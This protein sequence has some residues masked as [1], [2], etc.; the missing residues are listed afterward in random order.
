MFLNTVL[1]KKLNA[2]IRLKVQPLFNTF[3]IEDRRLTTFCEDSFDQCA[4]FLRIFC[5]S[6]GRLG[7]KRHR[8][9]RFHDVLFTFCPFFLST[10]N[11]H[12]SFY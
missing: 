12:L 6:V 3:K 2:F 7:Y 8:C 5:P 11:F 4:S 9:K 1:R 10:F